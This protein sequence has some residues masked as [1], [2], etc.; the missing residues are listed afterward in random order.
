MESNYESIAEVMAVVNDEVAQSNHPVTSQVK[1]TPLTT[2]LLP[3]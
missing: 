2:Y 1:N 3:D